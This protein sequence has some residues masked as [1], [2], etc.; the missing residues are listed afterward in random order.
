[1]QDVIDKIKAAETEAE[2]MKQQA[3]QDTAKA[4]AAAKADGKKLV[5]ETAAKANK[6]AQQLIELARK[7]ADASVAEKVEAAQ[8]EAQDILKTAESRME[9]AALAIVEGIVDSI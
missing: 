2:A 1:M 3:H 5:E 6:Q 8:K 9:Q 7:Q 4:E